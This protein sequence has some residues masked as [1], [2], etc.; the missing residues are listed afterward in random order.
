MSE[1]NVHV[2]SEETVTKTIA[3]SNGAYA[4]IFN[5]KPLAEDEHTAKSRTLFESLVSPFSHVLQFI[6]GKGIAKLKTADLNKDGKVNII[7]FSILLFW[8][9]TKQAKGLGIADINDDGKV[10]IV[11]FSIMLF[12]WTG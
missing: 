2:A 11:D 4:I 3:D 5:T 10:N 12:Q 7:D 9:N 8:W 6:V 1:V